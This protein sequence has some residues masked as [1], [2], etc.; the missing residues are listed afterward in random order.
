M[1]MPYY[2]VEPGLYEHNDLGDYHEQAHIL[3]KREDSGLR[4]ATAF[5]LVTYQ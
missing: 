1:Q 4:L 5:H 2:R 3:A